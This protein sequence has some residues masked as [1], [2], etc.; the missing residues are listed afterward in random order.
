[1]KTLKDLVT[2]SKEK[3]VHAAL[4]GAAQEAEWLVAEICGLDRYE[5]L[6][7][8]QKLIDKEWVQAVENGLQKLVRGVPFAYV[9]QKIAFDGLDLEVGPQVLIP[10]PETEELFHLAATLWTPSL[11]KNSTI[12]DLGTGSGCLAI[13]MA[14]RF[15]YCRVHASDISQDALSLAKKNAEKA[16]VCVDFRLGDWTNPWKNCFF[17]RIIS[18]PP[19]IGRSETELVSLNALTYE[20]HLA[21][22]AEEEGLANYRR[23]SEELL[24]ITRPGSLVAFEIG[25]S[26]AD[27]IFEFFNRPG[28]LKARVFK[29]L[30]GHQRFFFVER[31]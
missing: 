21:L 14:K 30:S 22:F 9:T 7:H 24:N 2:E 23:F 17:D 27:Q 15:P 5:Y 3:L 11:E 20:P 4:P 19:Y 16:G 25:F 31:E 12:L 6:L 8:P 13:A 18:N 29:D 26:Q 10:R 1:M 28:W